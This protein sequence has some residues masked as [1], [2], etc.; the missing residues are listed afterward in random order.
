MITKVQKWGNSLA[1]R[2]PRSVV[3]DTQLKPGE[4]VNMA[5]HD[6]QIVIA[7]VRQQ[8]F[9]LND[10]LKGITSRNR[11]EEVATG[12]AVGGEVW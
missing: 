10:L 6:G 4:A 1:V 12:N 7:A 5:S 2:I 9:K 3:E 8:R 11:H